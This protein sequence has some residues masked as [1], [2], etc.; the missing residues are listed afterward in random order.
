MHITAK[1]QRTD[2]VICSHS[3]EGKIPS[4]SQLN[5]VYSYVFCQVSE[6]TPSCLLPLLQ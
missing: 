6:G 2:L 1:F 4:Y 5:T 3:T